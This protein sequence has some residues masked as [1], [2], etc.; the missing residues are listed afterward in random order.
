M[1]VFDGQ[2]S[3]L[4]EHPLDSDQGSDFAPLATHPKEGDLM[5]RAEAWMIRHRSVPELKLIRGWAR[6]LGL[7]PTNAARVRSA[8]PFVSSSFGDG[9]TY[10]SR[11]RQLQL[12]LTFRSVNWASADYGFIQIHRKDHGAF[13]IGV[14]SASSKLYVEPVADKTSRTTAQCLINMISSRGFEQ[15][16]RYS[17]NFFY[18]SNLY[19]GLF[20]MVSQVLLLGLCRKSLKNSTNHHSWL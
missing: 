2:H 4:S 6:E 1:L 15:I 19:S 20:L 11:R 10:G 3:P 16:T 9:R 13:F 8:I 12:G 18:Y 5:R 14:N 17:T 7:D